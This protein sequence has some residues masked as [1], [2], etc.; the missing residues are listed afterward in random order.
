MSPSRHN[1]LIGMLG[2]L[3]SSRLRIPYWLMP[4]R[5]QR[6]YQPDQDRKGLGRK[7]GSGNKI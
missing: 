1:N 6:L 4:Q 7:G 2:I 5:R 3:H